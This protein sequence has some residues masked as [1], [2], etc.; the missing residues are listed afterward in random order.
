[1]GYSNCRLVIDDVGPAHY[2]VQQRPVREVAFYKR[3]VSA[4]ERQGDV[5]AAPA[6][7]VVEDNDFAGPLLQELIDYVRADE[8]GTARNQYS[9]ALE[10]HRSTNG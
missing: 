10:A 9:R 3:D 8:A 4:L 1:V 5:F 7:Q 6:A 2:V